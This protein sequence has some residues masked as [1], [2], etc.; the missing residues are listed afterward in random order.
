MPDF[1]FNS[2]NEAIDLSTSSNTST[3]T[4]VSG[5]IKNNGKK[6]KVVAGDTIPQLKLYVQ[7]E[8]K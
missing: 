8:G 1:D 4:P 6:Q 5:G 2:H 3:L 7:N